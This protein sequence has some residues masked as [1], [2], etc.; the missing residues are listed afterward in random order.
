M[1]LFGP[2]RQDVTE[3]SRILDNIKL[4]KFTESKKTKKAGH[5]GN[6]GGGKYTG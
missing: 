6:G 1:R 2:N 5:M 4:L 3:R